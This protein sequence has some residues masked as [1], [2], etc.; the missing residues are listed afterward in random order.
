MQKGHI[1]LLGILLNGLLFGCS[2]KSNS[3]WKSQWISIPTRW[4]KDVS[5]ANALPEYPRPQM[6]RKN[7]WQN[8]NGLWNY[9]ITHKDSLM[10]SQFD[11]DILVPYPVESALSGVKK[12]LASGQL[13]W[14]RRQFKNDAKKGEKTLLH[15]EA[16]DYEAWVYINGKEAGHHAGGYTSFSMDITDKLHNGQNE[17]IVKVYDPTNEGVGPHGK[18]VLQPGGIYYTASSGIWQT[19]WLENVPQVF[20]DNLRITPDVDNK[21]V[22]ILVSTNE[23]S[24]S[25]SVTVKASDGSSITGSA[26]S[27]LV[28][29]IADAH[30]WSPGDPY[31]YDLSVDLVQ[32]N[33][34][35][36]HVDSYFGMRKV[37]IQKDDAGFDRI[38]LN[39]NYT[40]NL[41]VLDQGFWPDGLYTAP[42]DDALKFDIE[43]I[44]A[45]GFNTI[46]KHIKVEPARWYY[47]AD[48]LGMLVWQDFVNPNQRLPLGAKQAFESDI[49]ETI[50]QLY[51]NPSIITWVVFNE[52]WGQYDQQRITEWVKKTDPTRLVNG[53]SGELLYTDNQLRSPADNPYVSSDMTD[54]HSY[55]FP[56]NAIALAGKVQVLGE[57]GGIGVPVVNHLW[58]DLEQG[59][60]YNGIQTPK[61]L[62]L[63]YTRMVDTLV[64]L[65]RKGLS[66]SIYTQPFDV[67]SE[68]NGLMTYDREIV[69]LPAEKI[70]AI[71]SK[72]HPVSKNYVAATGSFTINV[73][74]TARQDYAKCLEEYKQGKREPAFLRQLAI[75]A[76]ASNDS[77]ANKYGN[78]YIG[79]LKKPYTAGELKFI[80][81]F[82]QSVKDPGFE[83][84]YNNVEEINSVLG[85]DEA[86]ATIT[87]TIERDLIL[88]YTK[89]KPDWKPMKESTG[90]YGELGNETLLQAQMLYAINNSDYVLLEEVGDTWYKKYGHK[91]KWIPSFLLNNMAWKIFEESD[92]KNLLQ[93]ALNW[94]RATIDNEKERDNTYYDTYA[95]ILYKLG[96]KE[97]ALKMQETAIRLD[98]SNNK[99]FKANYEKMKR[100]EPTWKNVTK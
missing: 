8:L 43:A 73:A 35:M 13:L 79:S 37:S 31:L 62:E 9:A 57:F 66:A 17:I 100:G 23:K 53:H 55:P 50:K 63:Q 47:W 75:Y 24:S 34:I 21:Q 22:R 80:K 58:D 85:K 40:Y 60:G 52:R 25:L 20:I 84:L 82:T 97:E 98:G 69:K 16:V 11:G 29:P 56:R 83:I 46:R 78:E 48:K 18:Q 72:I 7:N 51:N 87:A 76:R 81:Q 4:V 14:Y 15:F 1:I 95:N 38:F 41:G 90:K 96:Q 5:P 12:S 44:K 6:V 61:D 36:D 94:S 92:S 49:T 45:L 91:R 89:S 86:E 70:R 74:D 54:V 32:D 28:L 93:T 67:E 30:L 33:K 99:E 10:P 27:E 88:P 71:N 42:T 59:W 64:L 77:S 68:Q 2:E 26:N 19:V 65:E 39:N 3:S